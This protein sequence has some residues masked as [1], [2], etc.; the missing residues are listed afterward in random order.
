MIAFTSENLA[1]SRYNRVQ[2]SDLICIVA[3]VAATC[4]SKPAAEIEAANARDF[5][6]PSVC[7][8][9]WVCAEYFDSEV[10]FWVCAC[11]FVSVCV[12]RQSERCVRQSERC[13][14]CK[15]ENKTCRGALAVIYQPSLL[16]TQEVFHACISFHKHKGKRKIMGL[17][18]DHAHF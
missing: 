10:Y 1:K 17:H 13:V 2:R 3:I 11:T 7:V 16:C 12:C 15:C 5:P 14:I 18:C 4:T 8:H 9:V 6:Q